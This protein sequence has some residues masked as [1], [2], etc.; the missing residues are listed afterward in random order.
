MSCCPA[1]TVCM[2]LEEIRGEHG[3]EW[4][5]SQFCET[6]ASVEARLSWFFIGENG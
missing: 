5:M 3:C 1:T 2:K 4:V 6:L